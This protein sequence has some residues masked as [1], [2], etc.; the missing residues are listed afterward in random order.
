MLTEILTDTQLPGTV[1]AGTVVEEVQATPL[2]ATDTV[3]LTA[4][5]EIPEVVP[6]ALEPERTLVEEALEALEPERIPVEALEAL[7]SKVDTVVVEEEEQADTEPPQ[8]H[9]EPA[10]N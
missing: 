9:P 3:V 4:R 10:A 7:D 1:L 5:L 8:P 2:Q 6:A